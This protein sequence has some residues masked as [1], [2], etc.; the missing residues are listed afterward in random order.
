[1][2]SSSWLGA[3]ERSDQ[4]HQLRHVIFGGEA[5]DVTTLRPWYPRSANQR[6]QLVNM[7]GIT[8]ITVH[9]TYHALASADAEVFAGS[10][11]GRHLRDLKLYILDKDR[12]LVPIGVVG[13]IYVGAGVARRCLKRPELTA[14]RFITS[15]FVEGDRLYKTGDLVRHHPDG[16]IEFLGRNDFQVKIRGYRIELGEIESQLRACGG[17]R[18]VVAREDVPGG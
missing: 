17:V 16:T 4:P 9:A 8:E 2:P 14:E 18:E 11:V 6:T 12:C 3:Q 10:P 13:E 15:P 1:V 7:Y 5:L